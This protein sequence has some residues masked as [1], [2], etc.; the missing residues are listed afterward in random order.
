LVFLASRI[1]FTLFERKFTSMLNAILNPVAGKCYF[2]LFSDKEEIFT[3]DVELSGRDSAF[4]PSFIEKT[5]KEFNYTLEDIERWT[6]GSGPAGFTALRMAAALVSG[7]TF[8]K[9]NVK[10]RTVPGAISLATKA[11]AQDGDNIGC[12]FDGRNK[13]ILFY[14]VKKENGKYFHTNECAILNADQAKEFF[15]SRKDI[16]VCFNDNEEV[17]IR[18]ILP[19]DL[20]LKVVSTPDNF[21]LASFDSEFDNNLTQLVYIRPAVSAK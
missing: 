1:P 13:E 21:A 6:L 4:L 14:G 19:E 12:L 16:L 9:D 5:L 8:R 20:A 11:N 17:A 3:K 15:A 7:W 18:K 10:T 2:S